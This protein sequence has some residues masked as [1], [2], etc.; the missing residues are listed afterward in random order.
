M[1]AS[2]RTAPP[3]NRLIQGLFIALMATSLAG[4]SQSTSPMTTGSIAKLSK[5]IESMNATELAQATERTGQSYEKNPKDRNIG[6]S[7]ASLL[8][9]SGKN[10]Q[11]LA[12]MQQVVIAHP[13]DREV[14]AAYGK[15]QAAAGQLEQALGTID[16]A[17]TPDRPDWKLKSAEGAILDQLGRSSEA[18]ARYRDALDLQPNE[19][20]ILSNLGMSYVLGGDLK[21][22]ETYL[23]S[24]IEQPTAD[25]RVRQ[26]LALVVGLQGRFDEADQI[27]R[28]ELST[29]QAEAN[30]AY[31]RS[32][33]SQ[34]N[35][36]QKLAAKDNN[37]D[38]ATN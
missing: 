13:S 27:A 23:R 32:M 34:Q 25:S 9:M 7:Y 11:A 37:S 4:C 33:L 1:I 5:P 19:P 10:E 6:M 18:R 38:T 28:R 16:R 15:T 2:H 36:W 17:Q 35:S 30:V 12:V 26:N 20:S 22:A 3:A 8:R 14:L 21:T 29:Q 24:A 31:L